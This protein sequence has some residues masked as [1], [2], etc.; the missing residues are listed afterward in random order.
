MYNQLKESSQ[1]QTLSEHIIANHTENVYKHLKDTKESRSET[2]QNHIDF[3]LDNAGFELYT[4]LCFADF[5]LEKKFCQQV[6]F[7]VKDIPWF[8]SD[9]SRADVNWTVQQCMSSTEEEISELGKRWQTYLDDS[10]FLIVNKSYW[11]YGSDFAAMKNLDPV[12][13]KDLS[14]AVLVIFKGDL[15]YRKLV[16][17]R[18]WPTTTSFEEALHGFC[19]APLCTL[20][21]L[22]ADVVVGLAEGKAE[23]LQ[24]GNAKWMVTGEYAVVQF[25]KNVK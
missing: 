9:A 11:T 1:L 5:L 23:Q 14:P 16:G 19:P 22:K 12:V 6:R 20:R 3:V 15:N 4:D 8:V 21:T 13:Y 25:C 18:T 7:H 2:M 24:A 17:D 10:R